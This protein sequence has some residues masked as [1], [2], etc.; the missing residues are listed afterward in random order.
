MT[1]DVM[2]AWVFDGPRR[3][4]LEERPVPGVG[5]DDVRLRVAWVGICGSDIH[6][7]AGESGRRVPGIVMGHEASGIIDAVGSDVEGLAVGQP[8]TFAPTMP[9]DG[10]CGH[11]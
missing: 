7:Y 8:V 1:N 3:M 5:P 4:R 11:T 2:R 6:G 10:S 9:C